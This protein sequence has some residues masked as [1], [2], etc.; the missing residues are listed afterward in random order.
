MIT[1]EDY[2]GKW[3]GHPDQTPQRTQN[4][5]DL[6]DACSDLEIFARA[7]GINFLINPVTHTQI[8]G[9]QYGGFR[10][11]SCTIGAA[12]SAHK[13]GLAVDMYDPEGDIDKWCLDHLD[14]LGHCGIYLENP[15]NTSGWSHWTIRAPASGKRVFNP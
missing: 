2:F 6:I 10:P 4:A 7:D 15:V 8:S 13:E 3:L 14:R 12:H 1:I 9:E 5:E 11:Q